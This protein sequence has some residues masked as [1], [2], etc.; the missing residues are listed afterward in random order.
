MCNECLSPLNVVTSNPAH[1]EVNWMQL[2]VNKFGSDLSQVAGFLLCTPVSSTKKNWPSRYNWNR[3]KR[4]QLVYFQSYQHV[5]KSI[6]KTLFAWNLNLKRN[7]KSWM[8]I[9]ILR[10]VHACENVCT[11][12]Q[13]TNVSWLMWSLIKAKLRYP[14]SLCWP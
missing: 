6:C 1:D 12:I 5:H 3:S 9:A 13:Y 8:V 4:I 10:D 11:Y 7:F 14:S 2:Y